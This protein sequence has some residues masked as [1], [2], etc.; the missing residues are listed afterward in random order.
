[1]SKDII[2][3]SHANGFPSGSYRVLLDCLA[4]Q[5]DVG[6]IDKLAHNEHFPVTDNWEHLADELIDYMQRQYTQPVIAVGHSLGGVLSYMVAKKR[7]DLIKQVILL[8]SPLMSKTASW[9]IKISKKLNFID[10]ITP[11]GR[12]IGRQETWQSQDHA[13]EYFKHKALF[14]LTDERC[15]KDYIAS[16]TEPFAAGIRLSFNTATE[17]NIFRT[18]PHNLHVDSKHMNTPIA[19]IYGKQSNVV[20]GPLLH[21]ARHALGAYVKSIEGSHLFPLEY[22]E[23]CAKH[24]H[25]SIEW[26]HEQS[27]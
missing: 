27:N 11:A 24:I 8:D 1:M 6:Y 12:S 2:H 19:L 20:R 7:P 17:I 3:F 15:L 9:V 5:Y 10:H 13:F 22:P 21:H 16:A 4:K 26:L 18:I 23:A 14:R 25:N